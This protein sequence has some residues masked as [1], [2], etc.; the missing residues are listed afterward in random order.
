MPAT[1]RVVSAL[2]ALTLLG[3]S[4]VVLVELL[5]GA[6]DDPPW[7][8]DEQGV[9]DALVARNWDDR[10]VL[11]VWAALLLLGLGLL[12]VALARG[13]PRSVPLDSGTEA[14]VLS[15]RRRSLERYLAGI[16]IAQPGVRGARA[17]VRRGRV[18]VRAD[19]A[20]GNTQ[21]VRERVQQAVN[22]RVQSL[23]PRP[24]LSTSVTVRS[25]EG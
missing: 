5:R 7:L 12:A 8:V 13:R 22:E 15:V 19:T 24:A 4:V 21:E 1:R 23:D 10:E 6:L 11:L 18:K 17:E 16:A 25:R 3:L 2:A 9:R 14:T 20:L